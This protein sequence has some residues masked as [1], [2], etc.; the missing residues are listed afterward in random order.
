MFAPR[1][2]RQ[3][4]NVLFLIVTSSRNKTPTA[5]ID[6]SAKETTVGF[7]LIPS[8]EEFRLMVKGDS[9]IRERSM[10]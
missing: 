8:V 1:S 7:S 2:V 10:Y 3:I 5:T 9:A 6:V 4:V